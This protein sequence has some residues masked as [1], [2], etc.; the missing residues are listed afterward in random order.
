M[1]D[2]GDADHVR[3]DFVVQDLPAAFGV[4]EKPLRLRDRLLDLGWLRKGVILLVLAAIWEGYARWLDN[5]LLFPTFL[6]TAAAFFTSIRSGETRRGHGAF[7]GD[8]AAGLRAR[9]G[10]RG[11]G[12]GLRNLHAHRRRSARHADGHVQ[13]AALHRLVAAGHDLVRPRQ[14]QH[15]LRAGARG[16]VVGGAEYPRGIPLGKSDLAH[17]RTELRSFKNGVRDEDPHPPVRCPAF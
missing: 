5:P 14:R 3:K 4:V 2:G 9:T 7:G 6:Q 1:H 8:A 11:A 12:D 13:S 16:P 10:A 17:G 15:H